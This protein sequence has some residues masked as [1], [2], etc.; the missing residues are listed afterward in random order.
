MGRA[1]PGRKL[2]RVGGSWES[3]ERCRDWE[4]EIDCSEGKGGRTDGTLKDSPT[5]T[6]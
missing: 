4:E 2:E 6:A 5:T 3:A 1:I